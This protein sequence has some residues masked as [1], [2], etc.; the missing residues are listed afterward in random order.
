VSAWRD[1]LPE[2]SIRA[3]AEIISRPLSGGFYMQDDSAR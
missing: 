2:E 3:F 1:G